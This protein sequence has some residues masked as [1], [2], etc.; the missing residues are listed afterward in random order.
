MLDLCKECM[1]EKEL[2]NFHCYVILG[3][4]HWCF[5]DGT[6]FHVVFL[7]HYQSVGNCRANR[8]QCSQRYRSCFAMVKTQA[9]ASV[10]MR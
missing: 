9:H 3:L 6:S 7:M 2:S 10:V 1:A 4:H 5:H 8:F